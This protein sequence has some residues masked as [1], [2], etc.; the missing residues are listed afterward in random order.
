[1]NES[2]SNT[3]WSGMDATLRRWMTS[4]ALVAA[5]LL[6]LVAIGG[7]LQGEKLSGFGSLLILVLVAAMAIKF[8]AE[9]YQWSYLGAEESPREQS[10]RKMIGPLARLT[11]LR[12]TLGALGGVVLPLGVQILTAGSKN[13]RP[14]A[15]PMIPAVLA[16]VALLLLI[17]AEITERRLFRL[18]QQ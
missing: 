18:S 9:A 4:V 14:V 3:T 2:A 12:Y 13:I 10:A 8:A 16:C 1:M 6:A 17:P 15:D 5:V 7:A 11:T